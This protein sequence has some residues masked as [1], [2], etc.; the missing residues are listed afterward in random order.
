MNSASKCCSDHAPQ[1]GGARLY[2]DFVRAWRA[3]ET[4][5]ACG[6]PDSRGL[7]PERVW[8]FR[9]HRQVPVTVDVSVMTTPSDAGTAS[10]PSVRQ[11][12]EAARKAPARSSRKRSAT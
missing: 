2:R 9:C 4:A 3:Q 10:L 6:P 12:A 8:L 5:F 7:I 11:G 1:G